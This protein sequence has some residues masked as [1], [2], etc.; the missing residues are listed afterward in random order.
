M[1]EAAL[2]TACQL[3]GRVGLLTL[4][5]RMLPVYQ[6]QAAAY[7]LTNRMQGWR[8]IELPGAFGQNPGTGDYD[9]IARHAEA[10]V[11]EQALDVLVLSGAVLAGSRPMIQPHVPVP[12]IDGIEAAAWQAVALARLKPPAH[13]AGSFARP[14][15]RTVHGVGPDLQQ[16]MA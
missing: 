8:A 12:V 10:L 1:L 11:R 16:R 5:G 7:G 6:E 13:Q 3:G 14:Q 4:G 15:G 9:Q 2:L